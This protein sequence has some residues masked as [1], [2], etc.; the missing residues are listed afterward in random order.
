MKANVII[1]TLITKVKTVLQ[2]QTE[3]LDQP[4]TA[5][6]AENVVK[7][8]SIALAE[9]GAEGHKTRPITKTARRHSSDEECHRA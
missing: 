3:K 4:L 7:V 6:N 5:E 8:L 2:N 9:G 1:E